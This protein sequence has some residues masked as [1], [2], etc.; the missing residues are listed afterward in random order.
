MQDNL[1]AADEIYVI[2]GNDCEALS[3]YQ[4]LMPFNNAGS[5]DELVNDSHV[6]SILYR[7]NY[8]YSVGFGVHTSYDEIRC[9]EIPWLRTKSEYLVSEVFNGGIT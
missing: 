6:M 5:A 4:G 9:W 2:M 8:E 1:P 3:D 7:A